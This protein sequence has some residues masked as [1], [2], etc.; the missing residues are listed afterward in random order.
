MPAFAGMTVKKINLGI[1]FSILG[2]VFY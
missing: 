1:N 2:W